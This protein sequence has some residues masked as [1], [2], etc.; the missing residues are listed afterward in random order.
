M[1]RVVTPLTGEIVRQLKIG[2]RV[3]ISGEVY[4]ARDAAHARLCRL[5]ERNERLPFPI[6]G[7]VIY[8]VGPTPAPPGRV[9]GSAGPTTA[10]RMDEYAPALIA[11]GLRGMIGKGYRSA[12]VRAAM[13]KYGAVYFAVTGGCGALASRHIVEYEVIA[14]PE[15]GAEALARI[16]L[17]DLPTIVV[18]DALGGD[19][20]EANRELYGIADNKRRATNDA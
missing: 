15:L 14:Y 7:A 11:A 6:A 8:Y 3:L 12:Q 19:L 16:V 1:H 20:Y 4:A 10:G 2:D 13:A 9:I 18:N 17:Q 5:L